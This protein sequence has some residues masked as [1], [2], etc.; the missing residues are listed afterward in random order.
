[1]CTT[2]TCAWSAASS[3]GA[4]RIIIW[5]HVEQLTVPPG[6]SP[7]PTFTGIP[8]S[9]RLRHICSLNL[10]EATSQIRRR[11]ETVRLSPLRCAACAPPAGLPLPN[12]L[13][14]PSS[15]DRARRRRSC[16]SMPAAVS[17]PCI[18]EV[19]R[20]QGER[21]ERDTQHRDAQR[22][23]ISM[24]RTCDILPPTCP[25][26]LRMPMIATGKACWRAL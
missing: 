11:Q 8:P 21:P 18:A 14:A 3:F 12:C 9:C 7:H 20:R 1:M 5:R 23:I 22:R 2:T 24:R 10:V 16:V 6:G 17:L 25:G 13:W 26:L 15:W 4:W 19:V